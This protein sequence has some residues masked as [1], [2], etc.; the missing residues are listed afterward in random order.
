MTGHNDTERILDAFLAPE[1]D[2]LPDRV[3][4]AALTEIARTPQRRALRVPWRF[5]LMPQLL[6]YAVVA[7][8]LV[9]VAGVG[10]AL[11]LTRSDNLGPGAVAPAPTPAP[12]AHGYRGPDCLARAVR[13]RT[14]D[15][16]VHALHVPRVRAHLRHP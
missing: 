2:Q 7:V 13:D 15:H 9:A 11:L 8:V 6:R 10:G 1:H 14:G 16:R 12:D 3:V 5:P 4:D